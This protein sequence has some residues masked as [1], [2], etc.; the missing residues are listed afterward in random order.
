M[1]A[2]EVESKHGDYCL[3][4]KD[5]RIDEMIGEGDDLVNVKKKE[6]WWF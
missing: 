1:K 6:K 5:G 3:R 2:D 4:S